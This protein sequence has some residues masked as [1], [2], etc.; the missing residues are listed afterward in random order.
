MS[1]PAVV[2]R[3]WLSRLW[4]IALSPACKN[5]RRWLFG[6]LLID[7]GRAIVEKTGPYSI[8][9]KGVR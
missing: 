2:R 6:Y 4:M 7:L 8:Q 1:G 5:S 9:R 3:G